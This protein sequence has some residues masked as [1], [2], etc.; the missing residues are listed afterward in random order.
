MKPGKATCSKCG[1][2]NINR[3]GLSK[4]G[5]QTYLCCDCGRRFCLNP[6]NKVNPVIVD[7]ANSLL[8]EK[9]PVSVV[10]KATR[11]SK[12]FLYGISKEME[13]LK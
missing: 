10:A 1:S 7:I 13:E 9:V 2:E 4:R 12:S 8:G 11:L 6:S 3:N 5:K